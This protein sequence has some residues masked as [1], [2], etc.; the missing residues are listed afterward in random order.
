MR[1]DHSSLPNRFGRPHAE[2]KTIQYLL[3]SNRVQEFVDA[4]LLRRFIAA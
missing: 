1:I 4:V 2:A 3:A